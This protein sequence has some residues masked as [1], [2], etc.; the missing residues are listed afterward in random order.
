MVTRPIDICCSYGT[1]RGLLLILLAT[2]VDGVASSQQMMDTHIGTF[3][4]EYWPVGGGAAAAHHAPLPQGG[5]RQVPIAS[6]I[7]AATI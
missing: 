1:Y 5:E 6:T 7:P 2:V 3:G 4:P